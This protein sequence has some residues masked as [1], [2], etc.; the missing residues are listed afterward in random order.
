[1]EKAEARRTIRDR[2][3]NLLD[4][5]VKSQQIVEKIE[6]L[7]LDA[8]SILLYKALKS[9]VNVDALIDSFSKLA[10]V[11]LPKV[12]GDEMVIVEIDKNTK[13]EIG[14]F[15]IS[16]PV[17]KEIK[18]EDAKIDLC[19]TPLLGFDESLNRLGKG[20]GY[21]DRFFAKCKCKK[22]GVAFEAQKLDQIE[23]SDYDIKL[24]M[25]VSEDRI[26]ANN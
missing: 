26:Y 10:K 19:I 13:Y 18:A 22:I 17:G 25:I 21:Y 16:E 8:K 12:K 1:M 5:D 7:K 4:K 15:S 24:D 6:N 23:C 11:Y 20:K 14:P 3:S 2:L 9:E